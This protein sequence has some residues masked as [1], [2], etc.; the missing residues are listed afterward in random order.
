MAYT[1]QTAKPEEIE[2]VFELY[3]KRVCWMDEI[4]IHQWNK[5][6]YLSTYPVDYYHEQQRLRNLYVLKKNDYIIGAV[7]LLQ[8]DDRWLDRTSS[9]AYYVHNLVTDPGIKG[10]GKEILAETEK[11]AI[12]KGKHF[13]RLDCAVDNAFLNDYYAS[14]GFVLA[15]ICKD[16][17]YIGN[18]REKTLD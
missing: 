18:R 15:G 5:T 13:L 10:A 14:M 11:L 17:D 2:T 9:S 4:D 1:F 7:V 6:D 16:G 3:R 12:Q 8:S